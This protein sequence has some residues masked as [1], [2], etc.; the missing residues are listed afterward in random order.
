MDAVFDIKM[1]IRPEK[2]PALDSKSAQDILEQT[3][4]IFQKVLENSI[5]AYIKYTA[6][7]DKKANASKLKQAGYVYVLQ[8]K[9]DN[10]GCKIAL[11]FSVDWTIY[12]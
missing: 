10:Q 8:L 5:Q 4:V 12:N 6:Y 3:E 2:S 11:Q 9:G 1:G 7:F